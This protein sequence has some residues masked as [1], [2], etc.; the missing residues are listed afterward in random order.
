[1]A[2]IAVSDRNRQTFDL[3]GIE[4]GRAQSLTQ[5][6]L[7][8]N[9][10]LARGSILFETKLP[11]D[12][13]PR[14]LIGYHR[15]HPWVSSLSVQEMP[16]GGIVLVVTQGKDVFHTVLEHGAVAQAEELRVTYSWDAPARWGRL[17]VERIAS[18][19]VFVKEL[20]NPKPLLLSDLRIMTLDPLQR[21][22]DRG[23]SFF[24]VSTDIEPV[25]P[26]P[27]LT[28]AVPVLTAQGYQAA[29]HIRR[30]DLIR[31]PGY[32]SVPV[33]AVVKRTVP[34]RG[35]FSPVRLRAPYFGLQQDIIVGAKQRLRIGGSAVEYLFGKQNVLV[36]AGHLINGISAIRYDQSEVVTYCQVL[37]PGNEPLLAAG[38]PLETLYL[39]RMRRKQTLCSAGLLAE[40]DRS[41]LPEHAAPAF[42]VL[43]HFEANT[44][45]EL[46]AA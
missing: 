46:R 18:G 21:Q 13:R 29:G 6:D 25:G 34:A 27:G 26:M 15:D 23:V 10:L 30:G 8:P 9:S 41:R 32:G 42:P 5:Q 17:S 20:R 16:S 24:A 40:Y 22:M 7:T 38:A 4:Q 35:S 44:L 31:S 39:G 14:R 43:D 11:G 3:S 36:P 33:L 1:M 19:L 37:M 12:G 2:W 45:A 28:S